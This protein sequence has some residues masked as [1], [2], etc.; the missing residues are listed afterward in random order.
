MT[1]SN[2][3][4]YSRDR[5][6]W[7][8]RANCRSSTSDEIAVK[9]KKFFLGQGGKANKVKEEFCN[10]CV[11]KRNC[12]A[13]ALYYKEE[14]G[15]WGGLT[16]DER[17]DLPDSLIE[18]MKLEATNLIDVTEVRDPNQ[19]LPI[20]YPPRISAENDIELDS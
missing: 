8:R 20:I 18:L 10:S 19:W 13:F 7:R 9:D 15:I 14:E 2:Y 16:P 5:Q 3:W 12:L 17:R 1:E 11:V 6:D 4:N